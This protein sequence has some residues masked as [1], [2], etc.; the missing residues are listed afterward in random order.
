MTI[1]DNLKAQIKKM[2]GI[3]RLVQ[4]NMIL[5][6]QLAEARYDAVQ[7]G[8][9]VV[10]YRLR[11]K[12]VDHKKINVVF[13]C[14][15]PAIWESLRSVYD[16]IKADDSFN[17][18][19]VAIPNKKELH[20]LGLNH[21]VYESEGAE[22]FWKKYGCI[23]GFDYEKKEWFDL[24][25]LEPDYVFFQQPYNITR[26]EAYKSWN[27]GQY[28]K[29]CYLNYFSPV[30]FNEIYDECTPSDFLRDISF[31]FTQNKKD[32]DFIVDRY[33]RLGFY[34][35]NCIMTG[36]PRY[37]YLKKI[38]RES[39]IWHDK[40]HKKFRLVWTPRWT[41]N[42]GNCHFFDFKDSLFEFC[43]ENDVELVFRPHP[44]AF[45]EWAATGEFSSEQQKKLRKLFEENELLHL[46]ESGDYLSMFY[47][48]DCLISDF[49]SIVYDYFLTGNPV[50]FAEGKNA[51]E[52][53]E[54]LEGALYRAGAWEEV[55]EILLKLING[56]DYLKERRAS[57][58]QTAYYINPN[59][60]GQEIARILKG[61]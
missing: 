28:A 42:E 43:I 9:H 7:A 46:D 31:Y 18:H 30:S 47:S 17:V 15:R 52:D 19:I 56:D 3:R 27:V 11:I 2:P 37:D 34:D 23:N 54:L 1:K 49:S 32:H 14:H 26:C 58:M 50:I 36:Y 13:V 38:T 45:L 55:K 5:E 33:R 61:E 22:E 44:Q 59:G 29:I 35:T 24:R 20:S 48:S 53:Y 16:A 4:K 6:Q 21:E 60:A 10:D 12:K 39:D 41:T 57:I 51:R 8:R 25:K 40:Q